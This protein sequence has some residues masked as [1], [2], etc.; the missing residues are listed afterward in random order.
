M[1]FFTKWCGEIRAH[2]CTTLVINIIFI[3]DHLA[4]FVVD[5]INVHIC[6]LAQERIVPKL[7][8]THVYR[9][10]CRF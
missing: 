2:T 1:F 4:V 10:M 6:H 5:K 3:N 9:C 8:T 7:V